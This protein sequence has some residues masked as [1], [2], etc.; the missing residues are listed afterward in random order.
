MPL[1][2]FRCCNHHVSE[3]LVPLEHS[4]WRQCPECDMQAYQIPSAP[5]FKF[6]GVI[7][8]NDSNDDPWEGTRLEG[9]GE[10]NTLYYKSDKIFVDQGVKTQPGANSKVGD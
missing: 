6:S 8:V 4:K 10:P 5:H 9:R 2:L 3:H 7:P 1:H